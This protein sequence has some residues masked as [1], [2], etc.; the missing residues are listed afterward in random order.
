MNNETLD[1]KLTAKNSSGE[2]ELWLSK[3]GKEYSFTLCGVY[4]GEE[5]Q[6]DFDEMS[7]DKLDEI[8]L[9]IELIL[10]T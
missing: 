2:Q 3:Q 10:A 7:K 5:I 1:I 6:I 9:Q 4:N 8:K